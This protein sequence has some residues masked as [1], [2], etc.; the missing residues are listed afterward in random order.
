[1]SF[2]G[3]V[4]TYTGLRVDLTKI[5]TIVEMPA[6]KGQSRNSTSPRLGQVLEQVPSSSLGP[7][8]APTGTDAEGRREA[9]ENILRQRKEAVTRTLVLRYYNVKEPA[10]IQCD[11]SQTGLGA[12]LLQNGQPVA[13][14]S[15]ALRSTETRYAQIG[16]VVRNRICL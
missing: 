11:A 12:V 1:M 14:A 4:A 15:R 7:H 16:N 3:H 9:Q 6:P 2:I 5:K 10:T 13:S 8:Q